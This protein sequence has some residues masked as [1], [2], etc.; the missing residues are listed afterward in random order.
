[1]VGRPSTKMMPDF[2]EESLDKIREAEEE[3][4]DSLIRDLNSADLKERDAARKQLIQLGFTKEKEEAS[5]VVS[6]LLQKAREGEFGEHARVYQAAM[7]GNEG[8][9]RDL[10]KA[11]KKKKPPKEPEEVVQIDTPK[12]EKRSVKSKIPL[13]ALDIPK[14][15]VGAKI[16]SIKFE[17]DD[18]EF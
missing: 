15:Q 13:A 11:P 5:G 14:E 18:G 8:K 2:S 7:G 16:E 12:K 4:V 9:A 10:A 17:D 6:F 1:M 3:I